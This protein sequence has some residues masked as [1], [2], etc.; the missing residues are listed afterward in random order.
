M[1]EEKN[2]IYQCEN[3]PL[4]G[5]H[6]KTHDKWHWEK[7]HICKAKHKKYLKL[8]EES[9]I[10]CPQCDGKFTKEGYEFHK[11]NNK[12]LHS[13]IYQRNNHKSSTIYT[14]DAWQLGYKK[15]NGHI[16]EN[17][18]KCGVF[19]AFRKQFGTFEQMERHI[20]K[21]WDRYKIEIRNIKM[22]ALPDPWAE[23]SRDE[24]APGG[25]GDG[26]E[27][28]EWAEQMELD[29]QQRKEKEKMGKLELK[30]K[31][32]R[33]HFTNFANFDP[34][35]IDPYDGYLVDFFTI[36]GDIKNETRKFFK[37]LGFFRWEKHLS[38]SDTYKQFVEI[39]S[40]HPDNN[41]FFVPDDMEACLC[42]GK[43]YLE[44]SGEADPWQEIA[45]TTAYGD[46]I[47][48]FE[49]DIL[50]TSSSESSDESDGDGSSI[51]VI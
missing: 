38:I 43:F 12:K 44:L 30:L 46:T 8:A 5:D 49:E 23:L 47:I 9:G 42:T 25:V 40:N 19:K 35:L 31:K 18:P 15:Y 6:Y 39:Q 14:Q 45:H 28:D 17:L 11:R 20:Y 37:G 29:E 16:G 2:N 22:G 4:K 27:S 41:I 48:K 24:L 21:K 7:Q 34:E 13:L 1:S 33:E 51:T 50:Y 36:H 32:Q 3:C 10:V 26:Y